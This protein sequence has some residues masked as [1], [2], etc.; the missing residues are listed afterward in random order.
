MFP[1]LVGLLVLLGLLAVWYLEFLPP[2]GASL[3][4]RIRRDSV[5]VV[6]GSV[7]STVLADL[8]EILRRERISRGYLALNDSQ[9]IV[10]SLNI[11]AH[12][13]QQLRNVLTNR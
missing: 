6:R 12:L 7:R 8:T 5:R 11:P 9:R 10:F 3:V 1:E 2:L 13:H 4:I